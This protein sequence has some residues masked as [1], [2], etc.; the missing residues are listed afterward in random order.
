MIIQALHS[1]K[2]IPEK[3]TLN[4]WGHLWP[5]FHKFGHDGLTE[6]TLW[7]TLSLKEGGCGVSFRD[8]DISEVWSESGQM[9]EWAHRAWQVGDFL[10]PVREQQAGPSFH[11]SIC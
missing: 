9:D 5:W 11:V 8:G 3:L 2:A 6:T 4:A 1:R 10:L 7:W